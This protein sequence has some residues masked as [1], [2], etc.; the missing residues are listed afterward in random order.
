[1][2]IEWLFG[3]DSENLKSSA[4]ILGI[5]IQLKR[6]IVVAEII[7]PLENEKEDMKLQEEYEEIDKQLRQKIEDN[8]QQLVLSMGNR[9]ILFLRE[10]TSAL[11]AV[12][13]Q[14]KQLEKGFSCKIYGGIGIVGEGKEGLVKSYK[15]A[16]AACILVRQL[17]GGHMM[18][19]DDTDLRFLLSSIP[20]E[21]RKNYLEKI[22]GESTSHEEREEIVQC[23]KIYIKNEGSLSKTAE[24][25]FIHKNTLQYRLTKIKN[26]TGYDPRKINE[27]I[28]L[29]IAILLEELTD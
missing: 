12:K 29:N 3:K 2:A 17:R 20:R 14:I 9:E 28:Y 27:E 5:D 22:W 26:I 23:L 6:R 8:P 18:E 4:S 21:K 24:E 7:L 10:D 15:T 1:M 11:N 19:Y 25:L 13:K 16:E